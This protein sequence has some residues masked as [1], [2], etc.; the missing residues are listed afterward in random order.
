MDKEAPLSPPA[1]L[2]AG[3]DL[4]AFE[5]GAP[6]LNEYLRRYA[7]QNHQSNAARTYVATRGPRV[8]GYYTLAASVRREE[9][10]AR[11]AKGLARH[12]IPVILLA[13][14]AVDRAEQGKELG[15]ALLRD[16]LRRAAQ[17]ADLIGCRAVLVHAKDEAA[18]AFH[19]RFGFEPSPVD[20]LHLFLLM[21]DIKASAGGGPD[22]PG[23]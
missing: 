9:T 5:C 17:A 18:K 16:A 4:A 3:H 19:Q 20:D 21:K 2:D 10:S 8:V 22:N 13:R 14:L 11:V 23:P 15:K 6:A 1:P 12:P 7:Y